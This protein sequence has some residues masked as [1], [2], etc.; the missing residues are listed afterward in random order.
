[1]IEIRGLKTPIINSI[2]IL[3]KKIA[4]KLRLKYVPEYIILKRSIDARKKTELCYVYQVGVCVDN[5]KTILKKVND[6]D[7]MLTKRVD[8]QLT[9]PGEQILKHH[10][11]V[12]GSG[13]AGLFCALILAKMGYQPVVVERGLPVEERML[14]VKTYYETTYSNPAERLVA[15]EEDEI[16]PEYLAELY[17][18]LH[19]YF[20]AAAG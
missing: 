8:Y 15:F 5:E 14:L 20:I 19:D 3:E 17:A 4:K 16:A 12:V 13:P 11:M 9:H 2:E 7:I 6:K 10:P 1:M 18:P